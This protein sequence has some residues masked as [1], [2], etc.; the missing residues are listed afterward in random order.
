M[1]L[2]VREGGTYYVELGRGRKRS[3]R[4]KDRKEA[5]R[6]LAI[7]QR[8]MAMGKLLVMGAGP[9][10][11][12]GEFQDQFLDWAENGGQKPSTARM[13]RLALSKLVAVAGRSACLGRLGA[14]TIDL[15][16]ATCRKAGC[17]EASIDTYVRHCKAVMSKAV[18]WGAVDKNP[19]ADVKVKKRKPLPRPHLPPGS[20]EKFLSSIPDIMWRKILAL[21]CATGRRRCELLALR[22][23]DIDLDRKRYRVGTSKRDESRGWYPMTPAA[24]TAFAAFEPWPGPGQ[25]LLPRMHPDTISD[26]ARKFLAM[27]GFPEV[28]LHGLRVSFGVEY[29]ARGGSLRGLQGLLGHARYSTTEEYYAAEIPGY[30]EDE[31]GRVTFGAVDLTGRL[32][33]VK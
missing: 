9:G 17:H 14:R 12:L 28:S 4:T 8:E 20:F 23:R 21:Y 25:F 7:L 18:E 6:R 19:F 13:N 24:V 2:F 16:S 33:A 32:R 26:N 30:L 1:R 11:T 5:E 15:L 29:L 22:G 3:L 10:R 31:A 27:A